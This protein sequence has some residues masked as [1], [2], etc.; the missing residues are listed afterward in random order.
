M[1][2]ASFGAKLTG[3]RNEPLAVQVSYEANGTDAAKQ[4][5]RLVSQITNNILSKENPRRE[6]ITWC[7]S[8]DVEKQN[9]V[10]NHEIQKLISSE[11]IFSFVFYRDLPQ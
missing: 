9:D 2:K 3:P 7:Y 10:R 4:V 8:C 1:S 5:E 11:K 6:V